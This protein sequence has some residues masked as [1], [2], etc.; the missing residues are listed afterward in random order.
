MMKPYDTLDVLVCALCLDYER[1]EE[2]I[3]KKLFS[4][5]TEMEFRYYNF[6]I[7]EAAAEAVGDGLAR[8]MIKEI[9]N[10]IGYAKTECVTLHERDYKQRKRLVKLNIARKLHLTD[11]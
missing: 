8:C 3:V 6:K 4:H 11:E 5:R 10:R 7:Y 2:G 9:G 1:R